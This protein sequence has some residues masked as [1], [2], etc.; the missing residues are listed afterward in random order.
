MRRYDPA[1]MAT[2]EFFSHKDDSDGVVRHFNVTA[3]LAAYREYVGRGWAREDTV[4]LG[5]EWVRDMP[6]LR[7]VDVL[8]AQSMP[9]SLLNVAP[10]ALLQEMPDGTYLLVDGNHRSY[11]RYDRGLFYVPA[12]IFSVDTLEHFLVSLDDDREQIVR[13][14]CRLE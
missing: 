4:D 3:M 8:K 10:V 14:H 9:V 5:I 11:A 2:C 13:M 12:V 1:T 7:G 6:T